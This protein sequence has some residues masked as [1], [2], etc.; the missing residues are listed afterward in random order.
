M[1][2]EWEEEQTIQL[3]SGD[4]LGLDYWLLTDETCWGESFGIAVT[5]S[6]GG[7]EIIRHI[8]PQRAQALELLRRMARGTV[9]PVTASDVVADFLAG[10]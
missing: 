3:E 7:E 5:D 2:R 1:K 6:G 10:A 4:D 8:T 9:T